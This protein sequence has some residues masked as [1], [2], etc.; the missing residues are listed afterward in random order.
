MLLGLNGATTMQC[1]LATDIKV[2]GGAGFQALEI[3]AKKL[4]AYLAH[5]TLNDLSGLL[6]R[7][8]LVPASIN[9]IERITFR[10]AAEYE[11]V[12]ARCEELCARAQ[13]LGCDKVVVVP[14]PTP[15]EGAS[16]ADVVAESVKVLRDLGAIAAPHGVNIAFEFLGFPW[17]SVRTLDLCWEIVR[18]TDRAN[19]GLVIDTCHFYAGTR[20]CAPSNKCPWRRS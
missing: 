20:R 15:K 3:W 18:E 8:R 9:S 4:D 13:A 19:V 17:C 6:R 14:S 11:A 10:P 16:R 5:N 7:Q 12:R 2:A 1:D